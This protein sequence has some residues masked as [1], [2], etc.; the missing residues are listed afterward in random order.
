MIQIIVNVF[1]SII[2][3]NQITSICKEEEIFQNE[4]C[5]IPK[6]VSGL[7]I[8]ILGCVNVCFWICVSAFHKQLEDDMVE[9]ECRPVCVTCDFCDCEGASGVNCCEMCSCCCGGYV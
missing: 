9:C 7:A 1:G 8:L 5:S 6:L 3:I 4:D 2:F